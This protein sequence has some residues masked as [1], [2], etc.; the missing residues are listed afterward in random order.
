MPISVV[1][2]AV[3]AVVLLL[4]GLLLGR[5]FGSSLQA[6]AQNY[7]TGF[8]VLAAVNWLGPYCGLSLPVNAVTLLAGGCLGA[9]GVALA[10]ALQFVA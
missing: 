6:V 10:A 8:G 2:A 9:P 1:Y 7:A 5:S 4:L 3:L